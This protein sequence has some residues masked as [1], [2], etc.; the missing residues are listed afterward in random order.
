MG[1][2]YA[3]TKIISINFRIRSMMKTDPFSVGIN[4]ITIAFFLT[5]KIL[6]LSS[7][8]PGVCKNASLPLESFI[9]EARVKRSFSNVILTS[10]VSV[11]AFPEKNRTKTT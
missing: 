10:D 1:I 8:G 6:H 7:E 9:S 11:I 3:S 2:I 5:Q 4:R